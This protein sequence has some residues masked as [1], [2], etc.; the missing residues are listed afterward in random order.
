MAYTIY[1]Q[2]NTPVRGVLFDMDGVILDTEKLYTRFWREAG[3]ALGYPMTREHAMGMRSLNRTYGEAKLRSY[4]GEDVDYEAVRS[5]RIEL[6]EAFINENGVEPKPGI[7]A[8]LDALK[9]KGIPYS[10]ATS[11]PRERV[12]RYLK[13]LGLYD[14]F[15]VIVSG[16]EV[17]KGKPEPDIYLKAAEKIGKDPACCIA[18]E[19]SPAGILS[20][21]RA[22]CMPVMVPDQDKPDSDTLGRLYA[23]CDSLMDLVD[24]I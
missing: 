14:R 5:K 17:P 10:I 21:F 13:P 20:A 24:L 7:F 23:L 4:F 2:Q 12:E 3:I 19:D 6:M 18:V 16:Y 11:S 1:K 15:N 8:L 22:G 9:A